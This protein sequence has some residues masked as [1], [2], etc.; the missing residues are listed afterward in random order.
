MFLSWDNKNS[1]G[2]AWLY[3]HIPTPVVSLALPSHGPKQVTGPSP[4]SSGAEI[5]YTF[6]GKDIYVYMT[7]HRG[8][9]EV[10]GPIIHS[11]T[12]S[13][14]INLEI[15]MEE[16]IKISTHLHFNNTVPLL[17]NRRDTVLLKCR[18]ADIFK[19]PLSRF[20]LPSTF[21]VPSSFQYV[22]ENFLEWEVV[23]IFCALSSAQDAAYASH[24][25]GNTQPT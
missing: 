10:L 24:M 6:C 17:P 2:Q 14:F 12:S 20:L 18:W 15:Q 23:G 13:T 22:K 1:K 5:H 8:M 16:L 21:R 25:P 7:K 19:V 4:N 3:K 11:T 9:G